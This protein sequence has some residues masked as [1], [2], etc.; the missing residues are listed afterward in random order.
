MKILSA[1]QMQTLDAFTVRQENIT[2]AQLMERA[3]QA[4]KTEI[5]ARWNKSVRMMIF[6]GAAALAIK[7][8][9]KKSVVVARRKVF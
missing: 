8:I 2:S 6:A 9:E 5:V 3:A 7:E 1:Q 4:L